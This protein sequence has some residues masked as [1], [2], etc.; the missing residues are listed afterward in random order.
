M[1]PTTISQ[2][3]SLQGRVGISSCR[4]ALWL[5]KVC[6]LRNLVLYVPCPRQASGCNHGKG[7]NQPVKYLNYTYGCIKSNSADS[8][9]T[10]EA[11]RHNSFHP[12]LGFRVSLRT[13]K[14]VD[15]ASAL[16]K[17]R[18]VAARLLRSQKTGQARVWPGLDCSF[19]DSLESHPLVCDLSRKE[20]QTGQKV[21]ETARDGTARAAPSR[22]CV[23]SESND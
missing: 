23:D 14:W 1:T 22:K 6:C 15:H 7:D 5:G 19:C 20:K 18:C 12:L 10:L 3:H 11:C 17:H 16:D 4:R 8:H 21:G 13:T 9:G 2:F